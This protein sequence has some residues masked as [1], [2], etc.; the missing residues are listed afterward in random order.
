V[1]AAQQ[2]EDKVPDYNSPIKIAQLNASNLWQRLQS[3][4]ESLSV[5]F[6]WRTTPRRN[7]NTVRFT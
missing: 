1:F 5:L 2:G 6:R 4:K 7:H 3:N